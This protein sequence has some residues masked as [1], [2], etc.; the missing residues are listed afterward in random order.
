MDSKLIART[1]RQAFPGRN[2]LATAGD[3]LEGAALALAVVVALL[4]V[5]FAGAGGSELHARQ[6]AQATSERETH[7]PVEA[8][9]VQDAP[10]AVEVDDRGTVLETTPVPATW[11]G[12]EGQVLT[13]D[14]QAHFGALAGT[15]VRIWIDGRGGV[16]PPPL[17]PAGAAVNA[18]GLALLVWS[19]STGAAALLYLLIRFAH[20]RMRRRR[21]E[22]EWRQVSHDW[23][24]R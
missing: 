16:T 9:L 3:R 18:A 11:A 4:A 15:T 22:L 23:T 13:G 17:S 20:T 1:V 14:V 12:P 19:G 8:V 5:P 6:R 21:W 24:A 10:P 2:E 7:R